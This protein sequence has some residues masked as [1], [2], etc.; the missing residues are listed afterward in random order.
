MGDNL[1]SKINYKSSGERKIAQI[2]NKYGIDFKYE[3]PV[4]ITDEQ[5]KQR[6]WYPDFYLPEFGMYIE[7][8][9]LEGNPEYDE[10]TLKKLESYQRQQIDIISI[11]PKHSQNG[12]ES[13]LLNQIQHSLAYKQSNFY[14]KTAKY[15]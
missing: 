6:I 3:F 14:H 11:C 4:L 2:L 5:N 9:G 15:R 13:Y 8:F 1:E 10:S 7:Y 12:L